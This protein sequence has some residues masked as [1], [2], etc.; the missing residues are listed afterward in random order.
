MTQT[1]NGFTPEAL[2]LIGAALALQQATSTAA[3]IVPLPGTGRFVA[4]GT[5][6]EV[7][8]LLEVAPTP[9]AASATAGVDLEQDD[10][11]AG[12]A[13][14]FTRDEVLD[15]LEHELLTDSGMRTM[16]DGDSLKFNAEELAILVNHAADR[17]RKFAAPVAAQAV[18]ARPDERRDLDAMLRREVSTMYQ[19]LDA[20]EWAEHL[21][22]TP[23][24]QCLETAI[25]KLV[26]QA[27]QAQQAAAPADDAKDAV[28]FE[29]LVTMMLETAYQPRSAW[30]PLTV[31]ISDE[32][33]KQEPAT[34]AGFRGAIDAAMLATK[35]EGIAPAATEHDHS[36]GSHVD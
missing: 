26:G 23:E 34:V 31:S 2:R 5:A 1:N 19:Y 16:R 14:I 30:A 21:A 29:P 24:G 13:G 25:T 4:I 10:R 17:V 9:S 15:M 33:G 18:E 32:M 28:R 12:S 22:V 3:N 6:G 35:K 8:R 11:D 36:E 27:A 20:G 7:A